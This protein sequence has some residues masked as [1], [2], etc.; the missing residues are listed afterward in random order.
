MSETVAITPA[1]GYD[2]DGNPEPTGPTIEAE[3]FAVAP[4]NTSYSYGNNG[5]VD[6]AEYTIYL[7][8]GTPIKDDD[9]IIVRGRTCVAR[10]REWRSLRTDRA[11]LEVLCKSAT[12]AT[13]RG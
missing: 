12:G 11:A 3:A 6:T 7:P 8:V 5:D 2:D 13:A 4:G 9:V 1:F 10:V